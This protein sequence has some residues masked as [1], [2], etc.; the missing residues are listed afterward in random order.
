MQHKNI[1]VDKSAFFAL[2]DRSDQFHARAKA[3]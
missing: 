2:L 3:I 1:Y